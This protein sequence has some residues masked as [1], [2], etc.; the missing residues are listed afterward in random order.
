MLQELRQFRKWLI[1]L[2]IEGERNKRN[3]GV[4][5]D[6]L[7]LMFG[8]R[9]NNTL[10]LIMMMGVYSLLTRREYIMN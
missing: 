7:V 4:N 8:G 3:T 1:W 10:L 5:V 6:I 9:F 2:G